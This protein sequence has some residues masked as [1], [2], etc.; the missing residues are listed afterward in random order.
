MADFSFNEY[1]AAVARCEELRRAGAFREALVKYSELLHLRLTQLR[2][3]ANGEIRWIA[4]DL[5]VIE[6][7]ADLSLLCGYPDTA[8]NL[9]EA[10]VGISAGANN[11]YAAAYTTLK[12]VHIALERGALR[13]ANAL[14]ADMSANIGDI[15]VIDFAPDGL[16]TWEASCVWPGTQPA[17]RQ[18]LFSR[19]YLTIAGMF[20]GIGQYRTAVAAYDRGLQHAGAGAP[21]LAQQAAPHLRMARAAALLEFGE[22]KASESALDELTASAGDQPGLAVRRLELSGK[23]DLLQ[24]RFGSALRR[25]EQVQ[26][27]CRRYEFDRAAISASL[28]LAHIFIYLNQT[29]RAG[30]LLGEVVVAAEQ[31]GEETFL[32]RAHCLW[33]L[34]SARARSL[35]DAVPVAPS[36]FESWGVETQAASPSNEDGSNA[37]ARLDAADDSNYLSWFEDRALGFYWHLSRRDLPS[38]ASSLSAIR[39]IFDATDSFVVRSRLGLMEGILAYYQNNYQAAADKLD[40]VCR[41]LT[42]L[43]LRP[44]LWQARRFLGWCWARMGRPEEDRQALAAQTTDLM[45]AL[46]ASLDGPEQA[47]YLLNKWTAEEEALALEINELAEL[48]AAAE[49]A[50]GVRKMIRRWR[51]G[52]R[53]RNLLRKV[54]Q[55]KGTIVGRSAP[56]RV[57]KQG[58]AHRSLLRYPFGNRRRVTLS[59]LVLPDRVFVARQDGAKSHFGVSP[60]TRLD[61]RNLVRRWHETAHD[62]AIVLQDMSIYAGD[63]VDAA[64]PP[65]RSLAELEAELNHISEQLAEAVQL[66]GL[67]SGLPASVSALTIVPDDCLHGLPFAALRHENHYLIE[68]YAIAL[69]FESEAPPRRPSA[70]AG[71]ALAVA[72]AQGFGDD[73]QPL[74]ATISEVEVVSGWLGRKGVQVR[75]LADEGPSDGLPTKSAVLAYLSGAEVFHI[76]CH[77]SFE[78]NQLDQTGLLLPGG[79]GGRA[80]LLSLRELMSLDL[81]GLQHATLTACWSADNYILPGRWIISL[82]EVIWRAGAGSILGSLWP[83]EDRV[84]CALIEKFYNYLDEYPR[85]EALRRAQLDCLR[86]QLLPASFG[87]TLDASNQIFWAGYRLYGQ[88]GRLPFSRPR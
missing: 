12:R 28:N 30:L 20:A 39:Q 49:S 40:Q 67:L 11:H 37:D 44:E 61:L 47:M 75:C 56:A 24:G 77:G 27:I 76:A 10:A 2:Q 79:E 80:A 18:V 62:A 19:L 59:F 3:T 8:D 85:D 57:T 35:T 51:L 52:Q 82:P 63:D 21:P 69:A 70:L 60:I 83:T 41:E 81:A 42:D 48:R 55:Y 38:A 32:M 87:D 17:D 50:S 71:D 53:V 84:A 9:L 86:G 33:D 43:G 45:A 29:Y 4:A 68:R 5:V 72:V 16:D 36:V 23:L 58:S 13:Q 31:L 14:L 74:P 34:A 65:E 54:D 1:E 26:S 15:E 73:Y 46:A 25:F 22:F 7:T 66:P 88:P 6:Q 64:M 78:P